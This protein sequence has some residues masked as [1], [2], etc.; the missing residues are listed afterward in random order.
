MAEELKFKQ[1]AVGTWARML[2]PGR[3][4][5]RLDIQVYGLTDDGKVYVLADAEH[6]GGGGWVPLTMQK[7]GA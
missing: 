4:I 6:P 7:V 2:G 5:D 3:P 1:I